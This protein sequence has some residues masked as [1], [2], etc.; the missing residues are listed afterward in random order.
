MIK[1][2]VGLQDLRRRIYVKAKADTF[3]GFPPGN[4]RTSAGDDGVGTGCTTPCGC[5]VAVGLSTLFR[6]SSRRDR[7]HKL[8]GEANRE[9]QCGKSARWV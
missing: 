4:F 9:A 2:S 3:C 5:S 8:W 6:K 1:A 7:S